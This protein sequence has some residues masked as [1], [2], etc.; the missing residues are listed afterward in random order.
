MKGQQDSSQSWTNDAAEQREN[1]TLDRRSFLKATGV[2][3]ATLVAAGLGLATAAHTLSGCSAE[4]TISHGSNA[5][6]DAL[7]ETYH[8]L[9]GQTNVTFTHSCDVLVVGSGIAGLSAALPLAQAG[10]SVIVAEKLDLLGGAAVNS[11]GL[12]YVADTELQKNAGLTET[13]EEAWKERSAILKSLNIPH[14]ERAK[15]LYFGATE[16][17]NI[18]A[19]QCGSAFE[20]PAEYWV[21]SNTPVA[22]DEAQD[23]DAS[24]KD[25]EASDG[26]EDGG[27]TAEQ[28]AEQAQIADTGSTDSTEAES[29]EAS[30]D[31]EAAS[32]GKDTNNDEASKPAEEMTLKPSFL[33]PDN[34]IGSM[35]NVMG[36]LRDTLTSLG[37]MFLTSHQ[38]KAFIVNSHGDKR[39]VRFTVSKTET[40]VDVK[41]ASII[42]ATGGFSSS[43]EYVHKFAPLWSQA[44]SYSFSE[45]G[46]GQHICSDAEYALSG[47]DEHVYLTGDIPWT[48]A[49]S[50]FAPTLIVSALGQRFAREDI[51]MMVAES[52]FKDGL[53]YWWTIF[54]NKLAKSSQ[55]RSVAELVNKNS[56]RVIGP[57]NSKE[58][59][60]KAMGLA[61]TALDKAFSDYEAIVKSGHDTEFGRTG[62]LVALEPPFYAVRQRPVRYASAGG[63]SIDNSGHVLTRM[64]AASKNVYACGSVADGGGEGIASC[65]TCGLMVGRSVL[66][67]ME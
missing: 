64:G 51:M 30:G 38:A 67:D 55:G 33:L 17:A 16:W 13:A 29:A 8:L 59:L 18:L 43:P 48:D 66:A 9:G 40:T 6:Q 61:E 57:T 52:C 37:V 62:Q 23:A 42:I 53:G 25:A 27:D 21:L 19:Q 56:Q 15:E 2:S 4:D 54:D 49:W 14:L 24:Q 7:D 50:N 39:G 11:S 26:N 32:D 28:S 63:V 45:T 20:D 22:F 60:A 44:G 46:D 31:G 36:P 3:S 35:V 12:M 41:A 65:G 10:K 1:F 5:S 47:M 34:G 58:E